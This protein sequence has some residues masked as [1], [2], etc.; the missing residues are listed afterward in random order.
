MPIILRQYA[1]ALKQAGLD[2]LNISLD[3]LNAHQFKQ[4]TQKRVISCLLDRHRAAQ[5]VGLPIKINCVLIKRIND[6]QILPLARWWF[7]KKL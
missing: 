6:N 5:A 1:A 3:S 2:D 7:S 4:L